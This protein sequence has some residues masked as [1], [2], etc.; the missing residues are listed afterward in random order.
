MT[1]ETARLVQTLREKARRITTRI[2]DVESTLDIGPMSF[3]SVGRLYCAGKDRARLEMR[4]NGQQMV[5]VRNGEKMQTRVAAK[6][7]TWTYSYGAP[8]EFLGF[9]LPDAED[10]F[11]LA[12]EESLRHEGEQAIEGRATHAFTAA[13]KNMGAPGTLDTRKGFTIA[14]QPK[15]PA[16]DL[17]LLIDAET[18]LLVGVSGSGR[19]GRESFSSRY[20]VRGIDVPIDDALFGVSD[21]GADFKAADITD[22]LRSVHDPNA[23]DNA[24]SVN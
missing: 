15:G 7:G 21:S 10:P 6:G 8:H 13:L 18:G 16:I 3:H 24:S 23:A 22:I 11:F 5:S 4:I 1:D 2:M 12:H 20:S 14:Y 19:G 17:R 9:I